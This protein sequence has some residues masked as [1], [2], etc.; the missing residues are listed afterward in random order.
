VNTF[1]S[2]LPFWKEDFEPRTSLI[3]VEEKE[4]KKTKKTSTYNTDL[5][6]YTNVLN[7]ETRNK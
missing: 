7:D 6:V 5:P 3:R 4:Q 2:F 1:P